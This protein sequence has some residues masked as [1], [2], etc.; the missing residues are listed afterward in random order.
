MAFYS[1][2]KKI[3]TETD[4]FNDLRSA[5]G[6][7]NLE[8]LQ[9]VPPGGQAPLSLTYKPSGAERSK[10]IYPD[11]IAFDHNAIYLG[12]LKPKFSKSD[13][14]KLRSIQNSSDA[15]EKVCQVAQKKGSITL[16]KEPRL[17]LLLVHA[18]E[19]APK[20]DGIVQLVFLENDSIVALGNKMAK[21]DRK[22]EALDAMIAALS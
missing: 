9:L 7:T 11:L 18:Q 17:V 4:I 6:K 2:V 16:S 10:T 8:I 13:V 12:E 1:V 5:L 22:V 14:D 15:F 19:N 3:T 20:V 21:F